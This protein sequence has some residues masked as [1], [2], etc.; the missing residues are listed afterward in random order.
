MLTP[1]FATNRREPFLRL[2][3]AITLLWLRGGCNRR[4]ETRP[5]GIGRGGWEDKLASVLRSQFEYG[6]HSTERDGTVE[7]AAVQGHAGTG[8]NSVRAEEIPED[9]LTVFALGIDL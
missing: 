5:S 3:K 7:I 4:N 9:F 2:R 8:K 1:D 6:P